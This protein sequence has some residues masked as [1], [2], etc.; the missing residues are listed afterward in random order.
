MK[1]RIISAFTAVVLMAGINAQAVTTALQ[2]TTYTF[3]ADSAIEEVFK[4]TATNCCK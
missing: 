4:G 3:G 1:N 2:P